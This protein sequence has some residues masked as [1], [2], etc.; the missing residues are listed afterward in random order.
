MMLVAREALPIPSLLPPLVVGRTADDDHHRA[1]W[2]PVLLLLGL[3]LLS[4]AIVTA[5]IDY[6]AL[7]EYGYP[8]VFLVTLAATS[9]MV[10]PVP[11]LALIV[12]AGSFLNP[13]L[14]GLVAGL[15]AA[16]G[17]LIGYVLGRTG[18][19]LLPRGRW[20]HLLEGG[21]TRF[22]ALVVFVGAAVPNPFFDAIGV[23]A[24]ALRLPVALFLVVCFLGK[25]LRFWLLATLGGTLWPA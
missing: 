19:S 25:A 17:E 7:G 2:R 24:G 9:A 6:R 15:A 4:A 14:V 5:P 8:A 13:G 1:L 18:R 20:S 10:V 23:V 16:L 22:G 12:V 21:L 11:Y 3:L